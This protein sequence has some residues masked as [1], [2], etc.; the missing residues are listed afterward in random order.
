MVLCGVFLATESCSVISL[1]A[2]YGYI[3]DIKYI[4][5]QVPWRCL[6]FMMIASIFTL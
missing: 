5:K 4:D 2:E 1:A 3:M 6:C